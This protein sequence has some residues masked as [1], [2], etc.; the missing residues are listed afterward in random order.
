MNGERAIQQLHAGKL[1]SK[2]SVRDASIPN[3]VRASAPSGVGGLLLELKIQLNFFAATT[4]KVPTARCLSLTF[5]APVG[6]GERVDTPILTPRS[7]PTVAYT[8]NGSRQSSIALSGYP[9]PHA[10]GRSCA[11]APL[12]I[13]VR[14]IWAHGR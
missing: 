4:L 2:N 3:L 8:A 9:H 14:A 11:V 5:D 1:P 10:E 7:R 12:K 6:F 13:A